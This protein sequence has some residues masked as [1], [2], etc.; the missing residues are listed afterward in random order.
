MFTV[1]RDI[2]QLESSEMDKASAN[3][4]FSDIRNRTNSL[5]TQISMKENN[6]LTI[7]NFVEKFLPIRVLN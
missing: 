3:A 5:Y 6:I 4:K 1:K 7:E 2:A